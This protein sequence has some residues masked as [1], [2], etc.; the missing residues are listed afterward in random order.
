LDDTNDDF[1]GECQFHQN[2]LTQN[3]QEQYDW[4]QNE[5][6][7]ASKTAGDDTLII[8]MGHHP[9]YEINVLPFYPLVD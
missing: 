8:V 7:N 5:I 1:E 9:I 2:I 3:C 6:I 4:F